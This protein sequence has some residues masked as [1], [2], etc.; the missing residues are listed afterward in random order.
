[1]YVADNQ[2]YTFA[3]GGRGGTQTITSGVSEPIALA[4]GSSYF[5][6]LNYSAGVAAFATGATAPAFTITSG[7]D[8]PS[9]IAVDAKGN[10]YVANDGNNTVTV[11]PPGQSSPS[12][13]ISRGISN[14][15]GFAFDSLGDLYVLNYGAEDVAVYPLGATSPTETITSGVGYPHAATFDAQGTLY[16]DNYNTITEYAN[17]ATALT[18][19]IKGVKG[20]N[21]IVIGGDG[22]LYVSDPA[23]VGR[24]FAFAPGKTRR[25][26]T[27]RIGASPLGL[28]V[29]PP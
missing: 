24:V 18:R 28:A 4:A 2:V 20:S 13:T 23:H 29:G 17:G 25:A 21:A 10:L 3:D 5:Y 19:T 15:S 8:K 1:V 9:S 14:P 6:V 26:R 22:Y 16:V 27:L 7:L 12:E 11:Y